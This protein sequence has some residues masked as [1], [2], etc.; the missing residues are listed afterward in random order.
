MTNKERTYTTRSRKPNGCDLARA[1]P[2][3]DGLNPSWS[4]TRLVG[5]V[6]T[7]QESPA[8]SPTTARTSKRP[9]GP[10]RR[11]CTEKRPTRKR[12]GLAPLDCP[13]RCAALTK[14][15]ITARYV[16]GFLSRHAEKSLGPCG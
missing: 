6:R 10:A 15:S 1:K 9:P 4:Q 11:C 3:L 12:S 16:R 8:S 14:R 13:P 2:P 7:P 5:R